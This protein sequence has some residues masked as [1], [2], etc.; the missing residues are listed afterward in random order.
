M[1]RLVFEM[2]KRRAEALTM[3]TPAVALRTVD[4]PDALAP[5]VATPAQT[6]RP[7]KKAPYIFGTLALV[8]A[9]VGAA[10]YISSLGKETT[11]DAQI[12]GHVSTVAARVPGEVKRVLV[13]D[14]QQVHAGDVL[15]EPRQR[16][17]R[18]APRRDP[19]RSRRRAGR[20]PRRRDAARSRAQ[21]G[22]R[23]PRRR[24]RRHRA[25]GRRVG[26]E[27]RR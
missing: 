24:A 19:R 15:V 21:A 6:A 20:P 5:S 13:T 7:R 3:S 16:R 14:N 4:L 17:L 8:A 18:R 23:E 26:L 10:V 22:R 11:D 25:G 12:E 2:H 9:G 27:P 1:T